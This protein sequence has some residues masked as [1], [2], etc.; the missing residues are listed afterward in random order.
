MI[1]I[2]RMVVGIDFSEASM[3]ALLFSERLATKLGMGLDLVHVCDPSTF[4]PSFPYQNL[5]QL[6]D[7]LH[8]NYSGIRQQSCRRL[9]NLASRKTPAE[10]SGAPSDAFE[11]APSGRIQPFDD[12][13]RLDSMNRSHFLEGNP[14]RRLLT[15]CEENDAKL[16]VVGAH[17]SQAHAGLGQV[18]R[19][20]MR[21]GQVPVIIARET[22]HS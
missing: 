13:G 3:T 22:Q 9:V 7:W 6:E 16:L 2:P 20:L 5:P 14:A 8:Q 4:K 21:N 12:A 17:G 1:D 11:L 19:M 18:A 15:F 10:D